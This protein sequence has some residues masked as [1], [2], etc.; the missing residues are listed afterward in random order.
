MGT[1]LR[2]GEHIGTGALSVL[3]AIGLVVIGVYFGWIH[4]AVAY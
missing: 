3:I 4:Q 2:R 1:Q